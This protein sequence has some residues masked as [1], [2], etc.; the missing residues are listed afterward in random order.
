MGHPP[1]GFNSSGINDHIYFISFPWIPQISLTRFFR[2]LLWYRGF[3]F[4]P[5]YGYGGF[6]GG[7]YESHIKNLLSEGD[8]GTSCS[9]G[10]MLDFVIAFVILFL[11]M[12]IYRV[13]LHLT[14]WPLIP[15]VFIYANGTGIGTWLR[16]GWL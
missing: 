8:L 3:S 13:P 15:I 12:F 5:L 4:H 7:K 14:G 2:M 11:L 16:W 10:R 9:N 6:I 1:T